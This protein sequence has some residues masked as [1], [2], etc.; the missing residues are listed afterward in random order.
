MTSIGEKVVIF[1]MSVENFTPTENQIC[2]F[3]DKVPISHVYNYV[4]CG[5]FGASPSR[6]ANIDKMIVKM[7][8]RGP[9][10]AGSVESENF[11]LG[12]TRLSIQ[13]P[14]NS[15]QPMESQSGESIITLNGEIYNKDE[16]RKKLPTKKWKTSGDTEL[17]SW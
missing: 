16:L 15:I 2:D 11:S 12:H 8:H 6:A 3:V 14:E 1:V 9:D 13:D 10:D 7:H 4:M 17:Q 5:V